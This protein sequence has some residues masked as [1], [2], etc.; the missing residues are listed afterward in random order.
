MPPVWGGVRARHVEGVVEHGDDPG[1][2]VVLVEADVALVLTQRV[3]GGVEQALGLVEG[4]PGELA[5][6]GP[7]GQHVAGKAERAG[8][9][10]AAAAVEGDEGAAAPVKGDGALRPA[11]GPGDQGAGHGEGVERAGSGRLAQDVERFVETR[12]GHGVCGLGAEE[13]GCAGPLAPGDDGRV[14]HVLLGVEEVDVRRAG[15]SG[16]A[17]EGADGAPRGG[18]VRTSFAGVA[19]GVLGVVVVAPAR[20]IGDDRAGGD[21]NGRKDGVAAECLGGRHHGVFLRDSRREAAGRE[22]GAVGRG[23]ERAHAGPARAPCVRLP[24]P[25]GGGRRG[26]GAG[27]EAV[28]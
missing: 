11:L 25:L 3:G 9:A 22:F 24:G 16:R 2:A 17:V 28:A 18:A 12:H 10:E 27:S 21:E 15:V 5:V 7:L 4:G 19:V 13:P 26:R 23:R 14:L 1:V 20:G 8:G 6:R